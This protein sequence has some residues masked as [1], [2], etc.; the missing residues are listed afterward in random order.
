[1]KLSWSEV[2]NLEKERVYE[3]NDGWFWDGEIDSE[4]ITW[5][6][7]VESIDELFRHGIEI[8]TL[9]DFENIILF[10]ESSEEI[11]SAEYVSRV[12]RAFG[13]RGIL[14]R[15]K[16]VLVGRPKAWEFDKQNTTE[17]KA[18]YR[19]EQREAILNIVRM[20]NKT[21]PV[22]QNMDFGHTDPQIPMPYGKRVRIDSKAKKIFGEF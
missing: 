1:M 14:E 11:P 16:G 22:I 7:C 12:Y 20:Y 10:T 13:E 18:E 8:P 3:K 9:K 19:K 4:G 6:G 21:V 15:I 5:G 2:E 17:Q